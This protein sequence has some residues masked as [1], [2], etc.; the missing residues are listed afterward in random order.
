V[1]DEPQ[2]TSPVTDQPQATTPAGPDSAQPAPQPEPAREAPPEPPREGDDPRAELAAAEERYKRALADL[3]NY[4]KRT[5]RE[6][7]RLAS[8]AIDRAVLSWLEV[9]DTVERAVRM[10]PDRSMA[11][12]LHAVLDQINGV[13]AR[14][15]VERIGRPGEPFD[16]ERHDAIGVRETDEADDRTVLD[17]A[18]A[19][20]ARG[21]R[22]LRPAQVTVSRRPAQTEAQAQPEDSGG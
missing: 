5:A 10:D 12:G 9:V 19:G 15:G 13:L 18:R 8:E 2:P 22:V 14:Q 1:T 7:D 16:P 11:E 3:D 17:V 4:R 21:G 6:L 20:Y